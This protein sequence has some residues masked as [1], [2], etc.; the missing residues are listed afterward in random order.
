MSDASLMIRYCRQP[1]KYACFRALVTLVTLLFIYCV[2]EK[3]I[4]EKPSLRVW[5]Y[6]G[7]SVTIVTYR[8]CELRNINDSKKLWTI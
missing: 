8:Y 2:W 3:E 1:S 5:G 7:R 4:K 6:V